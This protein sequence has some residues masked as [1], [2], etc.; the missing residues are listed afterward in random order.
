MIE[1]HGQPHGP[2]RAGSF[3]HPVS[4]DFR[5]GLLVVGDTTFDKKPPA[6]AGGLRAHAQ[7]AFHNQTSSQ[8]RTARA[9]S[10]EWFSHPVSPDFRPGLLVARP[11]EPARPA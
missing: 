3:S 7:T 11:G 9:W 4:P 8:G 5:P 6:G 2:W 1:P 10:A